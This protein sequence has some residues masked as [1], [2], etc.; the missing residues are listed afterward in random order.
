MGPPVYLT[1]N[2]RTIYPPCFPFYLPPCLVVLM[3]QPQTAAAVACT[4]CH[5]QGRHTAD[6]SLAWPYREHFKALFRVKNIFAIASIGAKIYICFRSDCHRIA[7]R[8]VASLG[9]N[10][11]PRVIECGLFHSHANS[12]G[13]CESWNWGERLGSLCS[14]FLRNY[15]QWKREKKTL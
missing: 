2:C 11:C 5:S 8:C 3:M 10:K 4:C 14:T 1:G 13:V 7:S 12:L 15:L 6:C 9:P